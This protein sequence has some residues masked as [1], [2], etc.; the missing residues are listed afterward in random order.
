MGKKSFT[1]AK[2]PTQIKGRKGSKYKAPTAPLNFSSS[3]I[4]ALGPNEDTKVK[5]DFLFCHS[6]NQCD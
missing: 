2:V 6:S 3:F 5:K 1:P 4:D